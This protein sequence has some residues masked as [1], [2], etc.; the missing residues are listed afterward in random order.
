MG[1]SRRLETIAEAVKKK[2]IDRGTTSLSGVR[3]ADLVVL[4]GPISTIVHQLE[5]LADY[6][7]PQAIVIDVGSTKLEICKIAES[8][9][10]RK[11][12]QSSP[13][14]VG[15]HPMAGSEK[16]GVQYASD[17]MFENA[18]CWITRRN[19]KVEQF[20][21][22]LGSRVDLIDPVQ[23]DK[24]VA[25]VSHLPHII[26]FALFQGFGKDFPLTNRSI[27]AF[28]RLSQSDP[29][30]WTD[31]IRSNGHNILTVLKILV[32]S[33][34]SWKKAIEHND[35]TKIRKF[36]SEANKSSFTLGFKE[37]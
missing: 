3:G 33:L 23:H 35:T 6:V 22:A 24:V 2:A 21:K 26:S 36:I 7:S 8:F 34:A 37:V 28:A 9:L 30:L 29:D 15:C 19:R 1:V 32:G 11:R 16:K 20:W 5:M 12:P 31:I 18:L 10:D 13:R 4:C 14:F 17:K 25:H 27:L